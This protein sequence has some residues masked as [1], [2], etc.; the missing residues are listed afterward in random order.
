MRI[1]TPQYFLRTYSVLAHDMIMAGVAMMI[2][3]YLRVGDQVF[4]FTI[5]FYIISI[6]LFMV[7]CGGV[8]LHQ[9]LHKFIWS[10]TSLEDVLVI[11]RVTTFSVILYAPALFLLTRME[12]FPR[13]SLLI[14]WFVLAMLLSGSRLGYRILRNRHIHGFWAEGERRVPVLL[15]GARDG[16]EVFIRELSRMSSAPYEVIG[17]IDEKGSRVGRNIRGVE[18]LGTLDNLSSILKKLRDDHPTPPQRLIITRR[19]FEGE[20]VRQLLHM[21]EEFGMTVARLPALTDFHAGKAKLEPR[22][23]EVEDLLGRPQAVLDR[24]SMGQMIAGKSI[25]VTGAGGSI[26]SE[27]CRQI[28]DFSPKKLILLDH[29]EFLLYQIHLELTHKFPG[30]SLEQVLCD[31][32]DEKRIHNVFVRTKPDL[33]FHA[34]ALKHVPMVENNKIEGI[35]TNVLGTWFVAQAAKQSGVS[36]MVMISTDKA[37]NPTSIMGL[38]KRVA[39]VICQSLDQEKNQKTR[40]VSVRFGNVLGSTGSVVP[41]FQS[42]IAR[43]GPVTVTDK[44]VKRYFMS[45]SEAVSLVLQSGVLGGED[46]A[47]DRLFVLDMGEAVKIDDLARQM[48][49]LAGLKPGEDI[50]IEYTGLRPGEKLY[51]ELFYD[52]E[53]FDKTRFDQIFTARVPVPEG[54]VDSLIEDLKNK[55]EEQNEAAALRILLDLAPEYQGPYS[56]SPKVV[57]HVA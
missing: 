55:C 54:F 8:V 50:K 51:E 18:V 24:A 28:A 7:V 53:Q 46:Q 38:T 4:D 33:V 41:L 17:I 39:E 52:R 19:E 48:I 49:V 13:A 40:F 32:R 22:P 1:R 43:G 26:G 42:Q 44:N 5:D 25:L 9:R 37:V 11:L 29:S 12:A 10:Y 57:K 36:Q 47:R 3:L 56:I 6:G 2:A 15:I 14:S 16:A 21:A 35:Q 34:A 20:R 27:L 23:I 45:I 30:L 31:V